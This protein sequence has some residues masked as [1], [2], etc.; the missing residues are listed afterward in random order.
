[1]AKGNLH[2]VLSTDFCP[3]E[4]TVIIPSEQSG[5]QQA[6]LESDD[7][8]YFFSHPSPEG[9]LVAIG[10]LVVG[11][12]FPISHTNHISFFKF[13]TGQNCSRSVA[14]LRKLGCAIKLST[15]MI[16]E[17]GGHQ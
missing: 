5:S 11:Q 3:F 2:P 6:L 14:Y 17:G 10:M 8:Y 16:S 9:T 1:M 13:Y 12:A 15:G 7:L 4:V